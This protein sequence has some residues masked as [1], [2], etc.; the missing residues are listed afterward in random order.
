MK[1]SQPSSW[2]VVV[3]VVERECKR[4]ELIVSSL[5]QNSPSN[6]VESLTEAFLRLKCN[7]RCGGGGDGGGMVTIKC[8]NIYVA[9]STTL[10]LLSDHHRSLVCAKLMAINQNV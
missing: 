5:I 8:M 9:V 4:E 7:R 10:K 2:R 3:V 1:F 6:A